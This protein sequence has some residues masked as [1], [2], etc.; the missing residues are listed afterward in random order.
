[1]ADKLR[2]GFL[3]AGPVTQAI[4]LPS[5]ARLPEFTITRVFDVNDRTATAVADQVGAVPVSSADQLLNSGDVD[6][7]AICSP[8][9][10]HAEQ[11]IAACESDVK[12]ILCEKPFA[13][14]MD[15][16]RAIATV[17]HQTQTPIQ[18]GA[19][20]SFDPGV[21]AL[22]QSWGD[23]P[24][25]VHRVHSSIVLPPN[26]RFE[27]VATEII[28]RAPSKPAKLNDHEAAAVT[29]RMGMLGLA[30]HD[31]PLIRRLV[32]DGPLTVRSARALPAFGYR[33]VVEAGQTSVVLH[34]AMTQ[35][36]QPDWRLRAWSQEAM[37]DIAFTPS[38]VH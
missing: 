35:N 8:H 34:A 29:V 4:H 7:V 18:V 33:V 16:A 15:Q 6:V 20:H 9:Q 5:L 27:D 3:G 37:V 24:G 21:E 1:M 22:T 23:L 14:D 10:F 17:A 11:V 28:G 26:S 32:G 30:T 25:S 2:V 13:V 19:M 12:A 31:L 36:W 38:Y